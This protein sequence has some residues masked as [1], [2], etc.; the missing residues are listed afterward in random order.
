MVQGNEHGHTHTHMHTQSV[1]ISSNR[2]EED[3]EMTTNESATRS[4][5]KTVTWN[6]LLTNRMVRRR[7]KG[8]KNI[9]HNER[10]NRGRRVFR[11]NVF[12]RTMFDAIFKDQSRTRSLDRAYFKTRLITIK[13]E[14]QIRF[15]TT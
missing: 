9:R 5:F 6:K 4:A 15:E 2:T 12:E 13:K 3:E 14:K 8:T 10:K 7:R 1:A 11:C